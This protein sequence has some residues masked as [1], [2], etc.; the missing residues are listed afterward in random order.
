[1]YSTYHICHLFS[2]LFGQDLNFNV[3]VVEL[4]S[5]LRQLAYSMGREKKYF[6]RLGMCDMNPMYSITKYS[7]SRKI[8]FAMFVL[9]GAPYLPLTNWV[10]PLRVLR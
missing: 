4:P 7:A 9:C 10:K 5:H 2:L 8:V 6:Y 1:M 3:C